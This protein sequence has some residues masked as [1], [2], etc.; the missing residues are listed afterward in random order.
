MDIQACLNRIIFHVDELHQEWISTS[1]LILTEADLQ[2]YIFQKLTTDPLLNARLPMADEEVF[3]KMVHAGISWYGDGDRGN[4]LCI[5]PDITILEPQ[6]LSL[7]RNLF[8]PTLDIA[9]KGFTFMGNAIILEIKLQRYPRMKNDFLINSRKGLKKDA[10]NLK[11]LIEKFR[12]TH[13]VENIYG[14]QI[15]FDRSNNAENFERIQSVFIEE[16]LSTDR[17]SLIYKQQRIQE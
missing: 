14:V 6:N 2:S 13:I 1:G 10:R 4:H 11:C 7:V 16:S 9:R 5:T 17:F 8:D 12:N 15:V 3:G